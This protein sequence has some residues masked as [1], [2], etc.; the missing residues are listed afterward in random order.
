[1]LWL[2][3]FLQ[4]NWN[5]LEQ[6]SIILHLESTDKEESIHELLT[7]AP[8][9]EKVR[10]LPAL[11]KAILSREKVM[12]TGL[13]RGVAISHGEVPEI[14][15]VVIA[16]G[17]SEKGIAFNAIDGHPV[18]ILFIVVNSKFKR[19]E[20]LEVLSDLIKLMRDNEVR[21]GI[22]CCSCSSEVEQLLHVAAG[23]T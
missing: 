1:M 8:V 20:Y 17:L 10:D 15:K 4:M 13:G 19:A 21:E 12:S 18:H 7:R 14:R 22:R 9:F 11:E 2:V 5:S 16:L 23:M 6:S 3:N